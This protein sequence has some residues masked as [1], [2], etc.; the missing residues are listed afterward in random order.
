MAAAMAMEVVVQW[1]L[2]NELPA[3]LEADKDFKSDRGREACEIGKHVR[4]IYALLMAR[5]WPDLIQHRLKLNVV[6]RQWSDEGG[7]VRGTARPQHASNPRGGALGDCCR[8][9]GTSRHVRGRSEQLVHADGAAALDGLG[10][11]RRFG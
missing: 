2:E 5:R 9:G 11:T 8:L 1:V 10:P 4:P 7:E 3:F 6:G